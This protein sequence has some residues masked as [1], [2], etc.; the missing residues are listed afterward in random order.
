MYA[1]LS[2]DNHI[3]KEL[4][5]KKGWALPQKGTAHRIALTKNHREKK[6]P[7]VLIITLAQCG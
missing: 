6:K 1:D 2:L 5:T 4:F 7:L 3:L